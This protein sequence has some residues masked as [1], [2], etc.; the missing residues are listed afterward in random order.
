MSVKGMANQAIVNQLVPIYQRVVNPR[1]Q[2]PLVY[3]LDDIAL[4][5]FNDD[6]ARL[7]NAIPWQRANNPRPVLF[8]GD[9]HATHLKTMKIACSLPNYHQKFLRE[10]YYVAIGGLKWWTCKNNLNGIGL[11][12]AK[13][14]D[15]G[16]QWAQFKSLDIKPA[17]AVVTMGTND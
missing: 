1:R 14:E 8:I 7:K 5:S 2:H 12:D 6:E 15:Y 11:S 16:V 13:Q 17:Y 9:S 3:T 10:S 4:A